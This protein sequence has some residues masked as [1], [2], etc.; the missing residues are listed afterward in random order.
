MR[1]GKKNPRT[2]KKITE[3]DE[4]FPKTKEL[5]KYTFCE[6]CDQVLVKIVYRTYG[7]KPLCK[8]CRR[9]VADV[10]KEAKSIIRERNKMERRM[11]KNAR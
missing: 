6:H 10:R 2:V 11:R 4:P 3:E 5:E 7:Y 8:D 9:K 1:I